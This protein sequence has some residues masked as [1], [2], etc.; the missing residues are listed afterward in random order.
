MN[1]K[2]KFN[3]KNFVLRVIVFPLIFSLLFITHTFFVIRRS[4][5]FLNF[6]G[7]YINFEENE[8]ATIQDIY[9]ELKKQNNQK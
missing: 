8:K 9:N 7:E 6:G 4:W 2:T 3:K 5:H 1:N